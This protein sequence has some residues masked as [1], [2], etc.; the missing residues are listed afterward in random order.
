MNPAP[1]LPQGFAFGPSTLGTRGR[2]RGIPASRALPTESIDPGGGWLQPEALGVEPAGDGGGRRG[3]ATAGG[4]HA[5]VEEDRHVGVAGDAARAQMGQPAVR[6]GIAAPQRGVR[7]GGQREG[8][9]REDTAGGRAHDL[10]GGRQGSPTRLYARGPALIERACERQNGR[11]VR[12]AR[13]LHAV[14]LALPSFGREK[15]LATW[16]RSTR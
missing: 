1:I 5:Q 14:D 11:A 13:C 10:K 2:P 7:L 15:G 12:R 3:L 6:L 9:K 4:Q 16:G 8:M